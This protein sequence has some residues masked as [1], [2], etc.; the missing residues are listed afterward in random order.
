MTAARALIGALTIAVACAAGSSAQQLTLAQMDHRSW[1]ARE[2]A[3]QGISGLAE[4]PDGSLW[5]GSING[6][7]RFDGRSFEA[8][9]PLIGEP[10][11]PSETVLSLL[12]ARDSALWIGFL[13][14]AARLA[15]GHVTLYQNV[16]NERLG[17]V[18]QLSQA[19]DGSIWALSQQ[20][21]LIRFGG[22]GRWHPELPPLGHSR[23]SSMPAMSTGTAGTYSSPAWRSGSCGSLNPIA[24]V[25]DGGVRVS[26]G[27]GTD[28]LTSIV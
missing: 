16:N 28:S 3:P 2:G 19:A 1:T 24:G 5:V 25:A 12:V 11:L 23:V 14:G 9:Q 20:K 17:L 27:V 4:A 13:T 26:A 22:D 21:R 8:F 10:E 18:E 6:L 15:H 7:F